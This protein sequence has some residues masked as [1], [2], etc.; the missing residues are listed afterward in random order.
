[1]AVVCRKVS[2]LRRMRN[3][4][5][6][7]AVAGGDEGQKCL[8][9]PPYPPYRLYVARASCAAG[10][11]ISCWLKEGR[12]WGI[13]IAERTGGVQKLAAPAPQDG[14]G[15]WREDATGKWS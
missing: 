11:V 10:E 5:A 2:P 15:Q 6:L 12:I 13:L 3:V 7:I 4:L 14:P 1:M 8:I 9:T